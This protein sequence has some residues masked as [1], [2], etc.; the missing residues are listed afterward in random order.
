MDESVNA[1]LASAAPTMSTTENSSV[2][3]LSRKAK[4]RN[5]KLKLLS[6]LKSAVEGDLLFCINK[7]GEN[8][9]GNEEDTTMNEP[10][11][12]ALVSAAPT[13]STTENSSVKSL[14]R[15]AK[16]KNKKNKLVKY[17]LVPNT[18][19]TQLKSAVENNDTHSEGEV[20]NPHSDKDSDM[21]Q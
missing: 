12:E 15:K 21:K 8:E 1:A 2:K 7:Q 20:H 5:K 18:D 10:V 6:Q 16:R 13:M 14:K 19:A 17:D 3:K 4:K 11:N 9:N